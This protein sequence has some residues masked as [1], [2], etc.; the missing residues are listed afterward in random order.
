MKRILFPFLILTLLTIHTGTLFAQDDAFRSLIRLGMQFHDEG[1]YENAIKSYEQALTIV[2]DS[3]F[4]YYEIA[5]SYAMMQNYD[6]VIEYGK[7]TMAAPDDGNA[8]IDMLIATVLGS[9]YDDNGQPEEAIKVYDDALKKGESYL[10]YFNKGLTLQL[11]DKNKEALVC[12]KNALKLNIDHPSSNMN[13]ARIYLTGGDD[14]SAFFYYLYFLLLEP[15]SERSKLALNELFS[16]SKGTTIAIP[17]DGQGP[18]YLTLSMGFKVLEVDESKQKLGMGDK[19]SYIFN[20]LY[21]VKD[22]VDISQLNDDI[23]SS[24]YTPMFFAIGDKG[25]L[26]TFAKYLTFSSDEQSL[27][28][29]SENEDEVDTLF[30]FLNTFGTEEE[31]EIEAEV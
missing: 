1:E 12:Y 22:K 19:L 27:K 2:P 16:L 30:E 20:L 31:E 18:L 5:L 15:Q 25:Y 21:S 8:D 9:V 10:L 4:A 29:M 24:F 17:N 7:K 26:D 3:K 28:W 23:C 11:M 6:K 14:V 13:I